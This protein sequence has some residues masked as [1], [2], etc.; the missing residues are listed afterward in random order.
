MKPNT[1]L[2]LALLAILAVAF[3]S[4]V[5]RDTTVLTSAASYTGSASLSGPIQLDLTVSPPIGS[6]RDTLQLHVRLANSTSSFVS[7]QV[8][9]QLPTTLRM[10]S[11]QLPTG[12]TSNVAANSIQ[13]LPVVPASGGVRELS[14]PLKVS[15]ADLA[16]PEQP[17]TVQ[18][19]TSDGPKST[20]TLLWI[21]IPP[22]IAKLDHPTHISVGQPLQLATEVQGPGPFVETWELGDGRRVPVQ[23]PAV[24]YPIA[25]IY[26]VSVTVRNPIG[27]DTRTSKLT[28]VPHVNAKFTPEDETPG[29]GQLVTFSNMGGG[30][31]PVTYRWDF[32]DGSTSSAAQP[33]H[34]FDSPGTYKVTLIAENTF[35]I[36]EVSQTV[37]VGNPPQ[38]DIIVAESA[39]A[40][41]HLAGEVVA[42]SNDMSDTTFSWEMGDGKRYNSAKINHAYRRTGDYYVT[43]TASNEFGET[44]VGRW[45]HVDQGILQVYMPMISN[46]GGLTQGSS[47]DTSPQAAETLINLDETFV[48]E[49]LTFSAAAP[50]DKLLAYVNEARRQFDLSELRASENLSAAAQKHADDMA[51]FGHTRHVGS[52]GSVPAERFLQYGYASSYAGEA[53]AWGFIDPRQAVEFWVNSPSHRPIILNPY[54]SE[55]GLGYTVDYKAPSVWYWTAEFGNTSAAAEAPELR[56]QAPAA[57]LEV[58]NSQHVAF[59]W[60]WPSPLSPAQQFA[61]YL[62]GANGSFAIGTVL[63]PIIGTQYR[64]DFDPLSIPDTFGDYQWHVRLEN[65]R[66]AEIVSSGTR[67]LTVNIDPNLPT[68]TPLP[69]VT[70]PV[71][72]TPLATSEP[73]MTVTA[74][75]TTVEQEQAP[76]ATETP[77]PPLVTAT[78]L[79]TP[80]P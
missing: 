25:G 4:L 30:Q 50:T 9:I 28:V 51:A 58:L 8:L 76:L 5:R 14:L 49:P 26:D 41:T 54:A 13:W 15:S 27:A 70:P 32:G 68:P 1:R 42:V 7:P 45:I 56:V 10:D 60:N 17:I 21:G 66:G 55:V 69:T 72:P 61:V 52:D 18:L 34:S 44:Q 20:A 57:D 11:S 78:P 38:A 6:P 71:S 22:R 65:N 53:T 46:F 79:P 43:M 63:E 2:L 80:S 73:T 67:A 12:V 77:L 24:V 29:L 23:S 48:M 16:R 47:A 40:G 64:L 39:P 31:Q 59:L 33:A 36:S 19:L 35:G 62:S 75:P 3:F 74:T 37:T